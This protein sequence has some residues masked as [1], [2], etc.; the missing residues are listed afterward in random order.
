MIVKT[1]S[2]VKDFRSHR[3]NF[4]HQAKSLHDLFPARLRPP[5]R[6]DRKCRL[7]PKQLKL[8]APVSAA[9]PYASPH[10]SHPN[11]TAPAPA[12]PLT[13]EPDSARVSPATDT[14]ARQRPRQPHH[15]HRSQTAPASAPQGAP[16]PDNARVQRVDRPSPKDR[17]PYRP[18]KVE[19]RRVI[20]AGLPKECQRKFT[21][22]AQPRQKILTLIRGSTKKP[23][24][25]P[26]NQSRLHPKTQYPTT[27][28]CSADPAPP[29]E[30]APT[31]PRRY[32]AAPV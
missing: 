12:P 15:R 11:Q 18:G 23:F 13:P 24:T 16:E 1:F 4:L 2:N 7:R 10:Q 29:S 30:S 27:P 21:L 25:H 28:D 5:F 20:S 8:R 22:A 17:P 19:R 14:G 3:A 31:Y 9:G 26:Q 32:P 6:R